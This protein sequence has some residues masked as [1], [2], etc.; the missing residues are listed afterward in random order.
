MDP[1]HTVVAVLTGVCL[2]LLIV[3]E[4]VLWREHIAPAAA[5]S[6]V[7]RVAPAATA[8]VDAPPAGR[9]DWSWRADVDD[10]EPCWP[11][12]E[13]RRMHPRPAPLTV[14]ARMRQELPR[15][16]GVVLPFAPVA[17]GAP[18]ETKTAG[19]GGSHA[20]RQATSPTHDMERSSR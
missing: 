4:V 6:R 9:P 15:P 11:H 12:E 10:L 3:R 7:V 5:R 1:L 14:A 16:M 18:A 19:G 20:G 2:L 8:V 13:L 17:A